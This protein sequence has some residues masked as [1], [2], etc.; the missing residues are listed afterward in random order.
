MSLRA[1][2]T[3]ELLSPES[4]INTFGRA[5][6]CLAEMKG[7]SLGDGECALGDLLFS[8][9]CSKCRSRLHHGKICFQV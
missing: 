3:Q 4:V 1:S 8:V 9:K 7:L 2:V 5:V 6:T